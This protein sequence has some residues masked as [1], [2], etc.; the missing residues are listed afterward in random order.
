MKIAV[1]SDI[2]GNGYALEALL[3]DVK[4]RNVDKMFFLGDVFGY[5]YHQNFCLNSLRNINNLIAVKG[6]HDE[7]FLAILDNKMEK[8]QIAMK[9][10]S[11]YLHLS[12]ISHENIK[13][14]KEWNTHHVELIDGMNIGFFHGSPVDFIND[15]V[16]PDTVIENVNVYKKYDVIFCGHTHHKMKKSVGNTVIYN[17]GSVGQQRDGKGCSYLIYDTVTKIAEWI[18][19]EYNVNNLIKMILQNDPNRSD[20]IE[21]LTRKR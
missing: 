17:P 3:E 18:I 7:M 11:S 21:V 20:F 2:H 13:F 19:L 10:G 8:K 12:D 16:Y 5:Y 4:L 14:V 9:Y 6:N 15:R 1:F